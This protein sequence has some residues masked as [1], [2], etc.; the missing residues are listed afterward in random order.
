[1]KYGVL[2]DGEFE[3]RNTFNMEAKGFTYPLMGRE[4]TYDHYV[5]KE[6]NRSYGRLDVEGHI[7]LDVGANIGCFSCWALQH[8]ASHVIA[9]EPEINNFRMLQLNTSLTEPNWK[10]SPT[11]CTTLVFTAARA[12]RAFCT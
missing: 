8:N 10:S 2:V 6:I 9:L 7:V 12:D 5:M 11:L 1:M 3:E 4:G